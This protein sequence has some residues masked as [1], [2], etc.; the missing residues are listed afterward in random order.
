M[1][2]FST[3]PLANNIRIRRFSRSKRIRMKIDEDGLLITG[4]KRATDEEL[5][6]FFI[7]NRDWVEKHLM[8]SKKNHARFRLKELEGEQ[9]FLVEGK[10]YRITQREEPI[11]WTLIDR[12]EGELL[13]T[14][15]ILLKNRGDLLSRLQDW[16][17]EQTL[18]R[19]HDIIQENIQNIK[20]MPSDIRSSRAKAKW[21]SCTAKASFIC[22]AVCINSTHKL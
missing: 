7:K 18:T 5:E 13:I 8:S 15:P 20:K 14:Y 12:K 16:S 1:S 22:I 9:Y 11:D 3:D 6:Q 10:W 4:P 19:A 2:V 21:G 17:A